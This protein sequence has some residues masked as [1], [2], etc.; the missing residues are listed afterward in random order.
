MDA[1]ASASRFCTYTLPSLLVDA[2]MARMRVSGSTVS[3]MEPWD[4]DVRFKPNAGVRSSI[5][6]SSS[7]AAD[8][9]TVVSMK[10][11]ARN[12]RFMPLQNKHACSK[13]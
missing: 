1:T 8:W 4:G 7:V 10:L 2:E 13:K 11:S 12:S 5:M 9:N 3:G 6:M